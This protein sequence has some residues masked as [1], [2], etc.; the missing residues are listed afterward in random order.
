MYITPS[1]VFAVHQKGHIDILFYIL[2][3]YGL[4]QDVKYSF[5]R[6][7]VGPLFIRSKCNSLHLPTPHS[8]SI[9][10]WPEPSPLATASLLCMPASLHLFYRY[11]HLYHTLAHVSGNCGVLPS[12]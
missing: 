4:S 1:A 12:S 3:R 7:T 9:S 10:L 6:Y 2:F 8:Q 11:V 5:L